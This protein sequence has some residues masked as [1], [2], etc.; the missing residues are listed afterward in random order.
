MPRAATPL[1]R[2]RSPQQAGVMIVERRACIVGNPANGRALGGRPGFARY[3][4][5]AARPFPSR[6]TIR[7]RKQKAA[8]PG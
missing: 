3:D 6:A 4:N 1:A 8:L 7:F 2:S 5:A